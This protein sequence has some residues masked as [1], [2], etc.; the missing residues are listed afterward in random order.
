[1]NRTGRLKRT[2]LCDRLPRELG[3]DISRTR[4]GSHEVD[5]SS[6]SLSAARSAQ[7][8]EPVPKRAAL[9]FSLALPL[10]LA[11]EEFPGVPS[12][13]LAEL[14]RRGPVIEADVHPLR[15]GQLAVRYCVD[16]NLEGG[17]NEGASNP[18]NVHCEAALFVGGKPWRFVNEISPGQG[19]VTRGDLW[20][21]GSRRRKHGL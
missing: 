10:L 19:D 5:R 6:T 7:A 18:A 4:R 13:V 20:R 11:A 8:L 16:E 3:H 21:I 14:E 2:A 1:V 15:P 12:E 17:K 9:L